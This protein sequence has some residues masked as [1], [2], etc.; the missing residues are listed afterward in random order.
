MSTMEKIRQHMKALPEGQPVSTRSLLGYGSR[1]AVDQALSRLVKQEYLIRPVRGVYVR[2]E[3]SKYV[4]VVPPD[5]MEVARVL[6]EP[7]GGLVQVQ[8]AEAARMMGFSTQMPMRPIYY[9]NG[10]SRTFY[11]G[12]LRVEMRHTNARKLILAGRPAG[13]AF[14]ALWYLG[15]SGVSQIRLKQAE[16]RL[17]A[18]EFRAL[19]EVVPQMPGWLQRHFRAYAAGERT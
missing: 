9:V 17:T 8:G 11:L 4:G 10:P 2:P 1:A 18:N 3:H 7:Y 5:P 19:L 16:N 12:N 14:T 15:K 6:A 13:I